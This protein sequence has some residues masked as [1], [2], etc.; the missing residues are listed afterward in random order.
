LVIDTTKLHFF[1][2]ATSE[3]IGGVSP[4]VAHLEADEAFMPP[5]EDAKA[6]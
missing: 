3:R 6:E 1:D 4:H 5:S 2:C